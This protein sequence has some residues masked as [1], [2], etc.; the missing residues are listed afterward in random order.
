VRLPAALLAFGCASLAFSQAFEITSVK[1]SPPDQP[2]MNA[3]MDPGRFVLSN[4]TLHWAVQ[5]AF[6]LEDYQLI[7]G[8]KWMDSDHF[9]IEGKCADSTSMKDKLAMLQALLADRFQLKY[10][11]ET[12]EMPGYVMLPA[13]TGLKLKKSEATDGQSNSTSGEYRLGGT[14]ETTAEL[15]ALV[16]GNLHRPVIDETG[17]SDH[18]DFQLNWAPTAEGPAPSLFTVIQEQLG[19]R[20]EARKV[21]IQL[22]IVES[23]DKPSAN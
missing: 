11:R 2:G 15:A 20:L 10:H 17:S 18:F 12:R 1:P 22:L 23:A 7:G 13:K 16:A 8:P 5:M 3:R 19:I 14:N 21:P 4:A 9:E 6:R